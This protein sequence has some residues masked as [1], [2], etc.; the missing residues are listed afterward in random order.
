MLHLKLCGCQRMKPHNLDS[1]SAFR[2]FIS[3]Q[4]TRLRRFDFSVHPGLLIIAFAL[5]TRDNGLDCMDIVQPMMYIIGTANISIPI[6]SRCGLL[7]Y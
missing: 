1:K 7:V 3:F 2:F 5:L 4:N 6:S